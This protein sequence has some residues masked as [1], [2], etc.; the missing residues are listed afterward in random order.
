[1]FI[2]H[3][4]CA[5]V[6]T[7]RETMVTVSGCDRQGLCSHRI[8]ILMGEGGNKQTHNQVYDVQQEVTSAV[9]ETRQVK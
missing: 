4:L 1:M 9:V 8:F 2:R 6:N 5:T 7:V 3:L